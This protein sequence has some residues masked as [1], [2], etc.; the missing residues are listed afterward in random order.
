MTTRPIHVTDEGDGTL[1]IALEQP[2]RRG[3]PTLHLTNAEALDLMGKIADAIGG[4]S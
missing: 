1:V 4:Q 2:T 3:W